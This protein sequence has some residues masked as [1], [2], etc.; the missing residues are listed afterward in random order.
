MLLTYISWHAM[1]RLHER[2]YRLT[3]GSAG[4]VFGCLGV[5]GLLTRRSEKHVRGGMSLLYRDDVRDDVLV[6]GSLKQAV[7]VSKRGPAQFFDVRTVLPADEVRDPALLEQ[8][9]AAN[10]AVGTWLED[11]TV[12]HTKELGLSIPP[13]PRREDDYTLRAGGRCCRLLAG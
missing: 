13:L 4:A 11:R 10:V 1:A 12:S 7:A 8:G 9:R 6:V 5:L 2:N 3:A